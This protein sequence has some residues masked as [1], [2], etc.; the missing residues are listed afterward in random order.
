M[1]NVGRDP[2]LRYTQGGVAVCSFSVAV[3]TRWNDRETKE[4]REK[5]KWYRVSAWR[6]LAETCN[7]YVRKGMQIMVAGTIDVSAYMNKA[8]EAAASIELTARTVQFLGQREGADE[9][10]GEGGGRSG[11]HDDFAPPPRDPDDIPF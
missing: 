8:G 11:D 7:T 5:T 4:K 9:G 2:E 10:G 6:G 3:T 1:G